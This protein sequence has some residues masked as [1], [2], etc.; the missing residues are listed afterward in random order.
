MTY[1]EIIRD[2]K[3]KDFKPIYLLYGNEPYYIDAVC[4]YIAQNALPEAERAFAQTIFYAKSDLKT[5][6]IV[7]LS[8]QFPMMASRQVIIVKEAQN[9]KD[10]NDFEPYLLKP[11][12]TTMLVICLKNTEKLDKRSKLTKLFEKE[13]VV[14]ESK[15]LYDNEIPSWL[16]RTA[17]EYGL[18]F[19]DKAIALMHEHIG[20]NLARYCNEFDKLKSTYK[21]NQT[22][23]DEKVIAD[24]IGINREFNIFELQNA[25]GRKDIVTAYKIIDYFIQN[26]KNNPLQMNTVALYGYFNKVLL[27]NYC[28]KHGK[29]NN[30][31]API[32][33]CSPYFVKDY[34]TASKNYPLGT[35]V[36]IISYIREADARSKGVDFDATNI[37]DIYQELLFKILHS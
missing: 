28:L 30:E 1:D 12:P 5:S 33:G 32:I 21:S 14:M 25:L 34:I 10:F 29:Q 16:N 2:L 11:Q 4:D 17:R 20:N 8:R 35:L 18:T 6:E 37:K 36:N 27:T 3:N 24:N 31:I 19:T 22:I 7:Q 23:I 13:A 26:P 15:K 9:L